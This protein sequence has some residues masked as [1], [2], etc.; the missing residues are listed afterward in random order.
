MPRIVAALCA[1]HRIS[2]SDFDQPGLERAVEQ[3]ITDF[4]HRWIGPAR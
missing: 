3:L 1:A 4:C 2:D